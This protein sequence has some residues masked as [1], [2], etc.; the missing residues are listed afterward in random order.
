MRLRYGMSLVEILVVFA[1]MT[2]L[3]G[4]LLPAVQKVRD[5]ASKMACQNNMKQLA[6]ALHMYHDQHS[7]FTSGHQSHSDRF[8]YSGWSLSVLPY[9]EQSAIYSNALTA[10]QIDQY[11]FDNPP[12]TGLTTVLK[13]FLCPTDS[14]IST[15]QLSMRT[16]TKIAFTSYLGVAGLDAYKTRNGVLYQD[17]SVSILAITDGTSNTLLLGERPPSSDLQYGWWYA[18]SGQRLTGSADIVLGVREPNV[19]PIVA[20][21]TCGPGRYPFKPASGFNDPC[22][23][24]H[25]WSPHVGGASFAFADGS[26]HFLG[27]SVN[28]IM[29]FLA[30]CAGGEVFDLDL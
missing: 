8:P 6:L 21:S 9:V 26:I 14:R 11:P 28:P 30:S 12:H 27:Y 18:G 1:I 20:G 25:Y 13:V 5:S 15:P 29:P 19:L 24:F 7:A 4:L 3:I 22:G 2:I 16:H 23:M 17:S 10:Y